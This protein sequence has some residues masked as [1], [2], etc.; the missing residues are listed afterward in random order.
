VNI[1]L[2]GR[3]VNLLVAPTGEVLARKAQDG[4]KHGGGD[5]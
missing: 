2:H 4:G 1:S 3:P 5:L